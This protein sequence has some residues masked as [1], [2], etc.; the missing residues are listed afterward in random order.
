LGTKGSAT[1]GL[2]YNQQDAVSAAS[3]PFSKA[4]YALYYGQQIVLGSSTTPTGRYS[5]PYASMAAFDASHGTSYATT[6]NPKG[7]GTVRL[8]RINEGPGKPAPTDFKCYISSGSANDSYNY[9]TEN[10]DLTP[11]ERLS[12]FGNADYKILD[13]VTWYGN[14]F[15]TNTKSNSQIA[16]D[17]F[18]ASTYGVT[19]S[20]DSYYNPFGYDLG[21][22]SAQNLQLR[23]T[24]LGDRTYSYDRDD[25]QLANGFK[26]TLLDRFQWNTFYSFAR[27]HYVNE[28][29]G[30]LYLPGLQPALGPSFQDTDGSIVC[31][32]AAAPIS[33]CTPVNFFGVPTKAALD[34]IAPTLIDTLSQDQTI[35]EGDISGDLFKLWAGTVGASLGYE[36]QYQRLNFQPDYLTANDL[37][38][39]GHESPTKGAFY[40]NEVYGE[41]YVPL[42]KGLPGVKSLDL[43]VGE[44][45]SDY[46][47]FGT[48]NNGKYALEYRPYNDLLVRATYADIFRSPTISNLYGGSSSGFTTNI[49]DPCAAPSSNPNCPAQGSGAAPTQ[50]PQTNTANPNLKPETGYDTDIGLVFSPSFYKPITLSADLW[51]YSI[52]EAISSPNAQ[53][54]LDLCASTG[55]YCDSIT[56]DPTT[57]E[58][59]NIVVKP[60][61][62]GRVETSGI[63]FGLKWALAKTRFGSFTAAIDNTYLIKYTNQSID[64]DNSTKQS[65]AGQFS[66]SGDGNYARLRSFASLFWNYGDFGA[67]ITNRFISNVNESNPDGAASTYCPSYPGQDTVDLGGG[68]TVV[69]T[70]KVGY[71]DY[72][73][74]SGSYT[75]KP[76]HT[77]LTLGVNNVGGDD[78]PL[79]YTG[80]NGTTD[81]NTY[82][83]M[84]RYLY[85]KVKVTFK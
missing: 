8:T 35:V 64:G 30:T 29:F 78:A 36:Y 14:A 54:E 4:P 41:F 75:Y 47:T 7:T 15:Y 6:C 5:L 27:E 12:F 45:F 49:T 43:I 61:N 46:S 73:D 57:G 18:V 80:F 31:G 3:R 23:L 56:R 76:L 20:A 38:D 21:T 17:P 60:S 71:A 72:V 28:N 83:E 50:Y 13:D 10:L 9:Q 63:D 52:K 34:T 65:Y 51:H 77:Q 37:T 24:A 48:T 2:N 84:G 16:P 40:V 79:I 81:S 62:I 32:T 26:G 33:G 66:S 53:Q 19:A 74:I 85:G 11:Q 25:I 70:R 69:C 59:T 42:L 1:F 82:N 58:V 67:A 22:S 55:L 68:V 39:A 44:R